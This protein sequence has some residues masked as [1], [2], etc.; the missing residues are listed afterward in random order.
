M[1]KWINICNI[2]WKAVLEILSYPEGCD[3]IFFPIS[4]QSDWMFLLSNELK[5]SFWQTE[6][7]KNPNMLASKKPWKLIKIG[8]L[9]SSKGF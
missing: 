2:L 4:Y 8:W 9:N 3:F 5:E 1:S 6:E 7:N